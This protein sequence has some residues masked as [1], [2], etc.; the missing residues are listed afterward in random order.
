MPVSKKEAEH[1]VGRVLGVR[2]GDSK[3]DAANK[4]IQA[5]RDAGAAPRYIKKAEALR[6]AAIARGVK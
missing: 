4:V 1:V 2:E 6:D 3:I 5:L